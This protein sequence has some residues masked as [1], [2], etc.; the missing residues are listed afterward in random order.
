MGDVEDPPVKHAYFSQP[1]NRNASRLL[2]SPQ[3]REANTATSASFLSGYFAKSRLHHLSTWK[4][5]LQDIVAQALREEDN[6]RE[7]GSPHLPP[8]TPRVLMHIDF[9]SFFVTVGLRKR[10]ELKGKPVV[11]CHSAGAPSSSSSSSTTGNNSSSTSEIASCSYEAR[12]FG[13][14]NGMSL[15][16]ARK[17][18]THIQPIPYAFQEYHDTS[19]Q[20][21]SLLLT[22]ADAIEAVSVDE[23][24]IDVSR[25]LPALH[26]NEP[27]PDPDLVSLYAT[28]LTTNPEISPPT[29]LAQALR[30]Q[31]QSKTGCSASIGIGSN[32]LL[33]RLATRKAKPGGAWH[34]QDA[35][36]PTFTAAL[37]VDDLHGIGWH[38]RDDL[39]ARY[40][41]INVGE[42]RSQRTEANFIAS[43]GPKQGATVYR[44]LTGLDRDRLEGPKL[45]QSVGAN[46][47]YAIRFANQ[48]EAKAFVHKLCIEVVSR[49]KAA[50]LKGRQVAVNVMVRAPDA[51]AEAPK[52]MG[53]GICDTHHRSASIHSS[54]SNTSAVDSLEL[55]EPKAWNLIA[56]LQADPRELRGIGVSV[57]K[58]ELAGSE[59]GPMA[60]RPERGQQLLTFGNKVGT[61]AGAGPNAAENA[62]TSISARTKV[63]EAS[64][65][66]PTRD[67]GD[68]ARPELPL[69]FEDEKVEEADEPQDLPPRLTSKDKGKAPIRGDAGGILPISKSSS[70]LIPAPPVPSTTN[71]SPQPAEAPTKNGPP[72]TS[73]STSFVH[74]PTMSQI[75]PTSL[76][77]LPD[78]ARE[79][80]LRDAEL[81]RRLQGKSK[82][83]KKRTLGALLEEDEEDE[84]GGGVGGR[85]PTKKR[86]TGNVFENMFRSG[87]SSS[88]TSTRTPDRTPTKGTPK[89]VTTPLSNTPKRTTPIGGG[90]GGGGGGAQRTLIF[91]QDPT[92]MTDDEIR[93]LSIDP[94]FLRALPLPIQHELVAE[95]YAAATAAAAAASAEKR[96]GPGAGWGMGEGVLFK[97]GQV[98]KYPS[99]AEARKQAAL[100]AARFAMPHTTTT[101]HPNEE[102]A[103]PQILIANRISASASAASRPRPTLTT[104][105]GT[106]VHAPPEIRALLSTWFHK[107]HSTLP[108][109]SEVRRIREFVLASVDPNP[110][111][112]QAQVGS[113][114]WDVEG[115]IG[116]VKWWRE[117]LCGVWP[118][119]PGDEIEGG[120]G[121]GDEV[122]RAWWAHW[123]EVRDEVER[124]I[125][126]RLRYPIRI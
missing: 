123:T 15:G 21:Y 100:K 108:R 56:S 111:P 103:A 55:I 36:V 39:R 47:N 116:A 46:V 42:L 102:E 114:W 10:P 19:L 28:Q 124:R 77:E 69:A 72:T 96:A 7:R 51:P 8:E 112:E 85:T 121:G 37:D 2:S 40:G 11:V 4:S 53:H 17:Y 109:E 9:D 106:S 3:W 89:K 99:R 20:L 48:D 33:A 62:L 122:A 43:L 70:S 115:A 90:G 12:A 29:A 18:C 66:Q 80:V 117:V 5:Q 119:P 30:S 74:V 6:G 57:H 14:K 1:S 79:E 118:L 75:D 101:T 92:K 105:T 93:A 64:E 83:T 60:V 81:G 23:A 73:T 61:C 38:T 13:V 16:Q 86:K 94:T 50:K 78:W 58:L 52:F 104:R 107:R 110:N 63:A 71:P 97:A 22:H 44:K 24:L 59:G 120:E 45:R 31:I 87:G 88:S 34:L 76:S 84:E 65:V 67:T 32:V 82:G 41:T 95:H 25:L 126:Q 49:L 113:V 91:A 26:N 35:D 68:R 125:S 98:S 54:S 27:G